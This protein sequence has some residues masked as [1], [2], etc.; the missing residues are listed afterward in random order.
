MEQLE[1]S[2]TPYA[3]SHFCLSSVVK[4]CGCAINAEGTQILGRY[5]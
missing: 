2:E 3:A 1:H 4:V 5:S